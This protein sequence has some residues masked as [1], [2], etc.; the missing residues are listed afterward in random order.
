MKDDE[1]EEGK[2]YNQHV[3]L[4]GI[5]AERPD[6]TLFKWLKAAEECP[7]VKDW[8][9]LRTLFDSAGSKKARDAANKARDELYERNSTAYFWR[10]YQK[11]GGTKESLWAAYK[12]AALTAWSCGDQQHEIT[13]SSWG[14]VQPRVAQWLT[15]RG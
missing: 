7:S 14:D 8:Q 2:F 13:V 5:A 10:E 6:D 3:G 9:S 12:K 15:F 4:C 11:S 1:I